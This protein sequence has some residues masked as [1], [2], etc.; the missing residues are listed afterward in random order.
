MY[1]PEPEAVI[2]HVYHPWG[3]K[4][5]QASSSI[6]HQS[7]CFFRSPSV[8]LVM[9]PSRVCQ[10]KNNATPKWTIYNGKPYEQIDDLGVSLFLETPT[11]S[12]KLKKTSK[13]KHFPVCS[14]K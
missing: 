5:T 13:K 14:S 6:Q 12:Q 3:Q 1:Q 7:W 10:P 4:T 11:S 8:I 2:L 9:N